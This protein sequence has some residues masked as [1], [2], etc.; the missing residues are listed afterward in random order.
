MKNLQEYIYIH[1]FCIKAFIQKR[2]RYAIVHLLYDNARLHVSKEGN[3][4]KVIEQEQNKK[5]RQYIIIKIL[6]RHQFAYITILV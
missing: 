6:I 4:K 5:C 2:R 1:T 3:P